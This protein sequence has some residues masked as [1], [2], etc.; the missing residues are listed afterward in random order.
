[1]CEVNRKIPGMHLASDTTAQWL[2]T[3]QSCTYATS[4]L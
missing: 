3:Q 1:M 4:S 2:I